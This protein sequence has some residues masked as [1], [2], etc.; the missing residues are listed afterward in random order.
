M[1]TKIPQ[2]CGQNAV[3]VIDTTKLKEI[4]DLKSDLNGVFGKCHEAK[5]KIFDAVKNKV[6]RIKKNK[7]HQN[8]LIM[9][10]HRTQN[11]HGLIRSYLYFQDDVQNVYANKLVLQYYL[12]KSIC[13]DVDCI[14]FRVSKHGNAKNEKPF[15]AVKKS[16]LIDLKSDLMNDRRKRTA[17]AMYDKIFEKDK[18]DDY[19]DYPRSKKQLID[20]SHSIC[21]SGVNEVGDLFDLDAEMER[22]IIWD[23][24]DVSSDIWVIGTDYMS[25]N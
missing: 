5:N 15:Y 14:S 23:H 4:D 21:M 9:R 2:A 20:I 1:A 6:V 18:T 11:A 25:P 7:M 22:K 12:N 13:G 10:V 19:G 3:F 24:S 8:E 16:A 17:S